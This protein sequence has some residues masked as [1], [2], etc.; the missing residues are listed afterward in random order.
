[1]MTKCMKKLAVLIAP[2]RDRT[3]EDVKR[4]VSAKVKLLK[5]GWLP[6]F[7]PDTLCDVLS[8]D[9]AEQRET[10]LECSSY[11]VGLLAEHPEAVAVVVGPT[12]SE[13]M[14]SDVQ[15]WLACG[16]KPP[17]NIRNLLQKMELDDGRDD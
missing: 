9:D 14:I 12:M 3:P 4:L 8:D 2:F 1:M 6:V 17:V 10:A 13:G 15:T 7:L 16:G 11:F 5:H